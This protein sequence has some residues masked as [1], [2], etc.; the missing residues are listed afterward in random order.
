[1]KRKPIVG[2]T[3]YSLNVGNAARRTEKKL[4]PVTVISVGR[5][6][7]TCQP[8]GST[9]KWS[10]TKYHLDKWSEATDCTTNSRLYETEQEWLDEKEADEIALTL[11]RLFS[12]Y[13]RC[14]LNIDQLRSIK[15]I[16]N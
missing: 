13:G 5:K 4:T 8:V 10:E 3:L 15:D 7:F 9:G 11:R 12:G 14:P 16:I 6:Y 2:E 1:M